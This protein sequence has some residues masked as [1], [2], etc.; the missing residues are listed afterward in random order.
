[1]ADEV[2]VSGTIKLVKGNAILSRSVS[3]HQKTQTGDGAQYGIQNIGTSAEAI[4]LGDVTTE[5][6]AYMRNLDLTNY[7]Q[8]GVDSSGFIAF[9]KLDPG[10]FLIAPLDGTLTH[11]AKADT[12]AV[13]LEYI[14]I[15]D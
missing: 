10:D 4:N 3:T 5:G 13:E 12:A 9:A 11:Q 2:S 7:V 1:M 14:I 15:E 8:I 6:Y